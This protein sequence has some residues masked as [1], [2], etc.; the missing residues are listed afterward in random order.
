MSKVILNDFKK[1]SSIDLH[2]VLS[3]ISPCLSHSSDITVLGILASGLP[4]CILPGV[5]AVCVH[6]YTGKGHIS[7]E[8]FLGK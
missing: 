2:K 6:T 5:C 7:R 1:T 8:G 4:V 3:E